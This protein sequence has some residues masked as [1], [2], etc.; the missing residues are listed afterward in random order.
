MSVPSPQ[1]SRQD[2][3]V[4]ATPAVFVLIWSTGFIV[5]R[6]GMPHAPPMKFLVVRYFLSVLCFLVWALLAR[7]TWPSGGR[8]WLH[9]SLT[10]ILMHAGYLGGV[11]AAVKAGMGAGLAA[12]LVGL[13]PVL[14]AFWISALGGA[15]SRRQW[16]GLALGLGGL[17]L[18][19]WQ[20]LGLGEVHG[21]N[22][23][24]AFIALLSITCGT[25]YQK[26]FVQPCDVRT[27]NMV[28]LAAAFVLTLPLA[29]LET[30]AM[31]WWGPSGGLNVELA[32]AMAW[33]VLALTLGGS[34]LLYLLIQRG[35]ATS[36]TSL[37]YLVPPTTA[38]MAWVLFDEPITALTIAG[39]ALTAF[40]VSLV[41][42]APAARPA[43]VL[44]T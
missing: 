15:V 22:L 23:L 30:E 24:F 13:Q 43:P 33:S 39:V 5:A 2:F 27:A 42:R 38:L 35:A 37:M 14:T 40:G 20:K 6:F 32:G 11:W 41:V 19:V 17:V 29:L 16:A 9:L 8:Q 34:S 31:R 28:Q 18:V 21:L 36:V 26:R 3:F 25:L 4:R 7:A 44:R 12:L 10:G 1:D